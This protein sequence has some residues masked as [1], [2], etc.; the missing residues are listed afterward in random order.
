MSSKPFQ[1]I[2]RLQGKPSHF[3][4]DEMEHT[5]N[6]ITGCCDVHGKQCICG[7][8]MHYQPTYGGYYYEC[9]K[10]HKKAT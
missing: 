8:F 3:I 9:E 2:R 4:M 5:T 1:G 6:S 7:G 10:C